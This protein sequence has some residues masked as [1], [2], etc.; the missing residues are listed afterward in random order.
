MKKADGDGGGNGNVKEMDD[1]MDTSE[2]RN[3]PSDFSMPNALFGGSGVAFSGGTLTACTQF[4]VTSGWAAPWG[5]SSPVI[6]GPNQRPMH[7]H[8]LIYNFFCM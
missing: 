8:P 2:A 1:S 5:S 3:G 7:T 4:V 6:G